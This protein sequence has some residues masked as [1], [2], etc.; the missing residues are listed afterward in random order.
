[1]SKKNSPNPSVWAD[2]LVNDP[3][4]SVL[5]LLQGAKHWGDSQTNI[6]HYDYGT[7]STLLVKEAQYKWARL[8]D[9]LDSMAN[10]GPG[11]NQGGGT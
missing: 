4:F 10:A 8:L 2:A 5:M 7:G 11:Q 9:L 1:M 6:L 3:G